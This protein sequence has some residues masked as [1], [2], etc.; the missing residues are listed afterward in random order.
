MAVLHSRHKQLIIKGQDMKKFN[1]QVKVGT[2]VMMHGEGGYREVIYVSEG[3]QWI[4]V[5][6]IEG[7]HQAGHIVKYANKSNS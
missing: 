5:R 6:G 1:R 4:K 3:R 7:S 2:N